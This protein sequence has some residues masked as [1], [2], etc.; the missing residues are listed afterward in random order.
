MF[1]QAM[2][3]QYRIPDQVLGISVNRPDFSGVSK[4]MTAGSTQLA[5]VRFADHLYIH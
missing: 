2:A 5:V 3:Q 4:A 1:W